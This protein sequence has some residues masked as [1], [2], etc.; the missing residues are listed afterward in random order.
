MRVLL[1]EQLDVTLQRL[2]AEDLDVVTVRQRRW[3]G[4]KNGDLLRTAEKEFDVLVTMDKNLEHQ[5]N[6]STIR[7]G[8]VL[9]RA[10]SNIYDDVAPLIPRVDESIRRVRPGKI[11]YVVA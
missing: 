9:I 11:V 4:L 3:N 8:I 1:D 5:Q 2:F 10:K 6:L 7:L